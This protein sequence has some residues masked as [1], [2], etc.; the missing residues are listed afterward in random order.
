VNK[1]R[2]SEGLPQQELHIP[3]FLRL[4]FSQLLSFS[5][6]CYIRQQWVETVKTIK[7]KLRLS[8]GLPSIENFSIIFSNLLQQIK[9]NQI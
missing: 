6:F 5:Q 9:I 4:E 1:L 2:L 8:E 3:F 7:N